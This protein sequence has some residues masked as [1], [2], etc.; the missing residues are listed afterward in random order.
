MG[1]SEDRV[2]EGHTASPWSRER[3]SCAAAVLPRVLTDDLLLLMLLHSSVH[4]GED[5]VRDH[6][7][8]EADMSLHG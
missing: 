1:T 5:D 7:Q 6:A 3:F 2:T 4:Q 8:I